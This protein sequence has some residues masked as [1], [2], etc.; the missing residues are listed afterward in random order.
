MKEFWMRKILSIVVLI[1]GVTVA[2]AQTLDSAI[3]NAAGE[4]SRNLQERSTVVVISFQADSERLTN[5]VIDELNGKL[6]NIGKIIPVE[7]RQLNAIRSE[8]NFNISGDVSDESAQRIGQMLGSRYII[9]GSIDFIGNQYRIRFRAITTETASIV[10]AYTQNIKSDTVLGSLMGGT[11]STVDFTPQERWGASGLNLFFGL[12]SFTMQKDN[13][14]GGITATLEG[15]GV[16]AM[17]TGGILF[18]AFDSDWTDNILD[19]Y[20]AYPFFG[21]LGLYLIGAVYGIIRAQAYTR[22]GSQV[23]ISP[24]DRFQINLVSLK[25]SNIAFQISYKWEY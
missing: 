11:S 17:I 10:Y 21:G 15:L 2:Y 5:Y 14:G 3:E 9:M 8:L 20:F 16:V 18:E 22:P 6:A 25:S 7:R 23:T 4:F 13:F 24:F 12:G 1:F 19:S